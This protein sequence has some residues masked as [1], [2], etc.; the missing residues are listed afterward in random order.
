MA[1]GIARLNIF[2]SEFEWQIVNSFGF[3]LV[4]YRAQGITVSAVQIFRV[5]AF[6]S[7][8]YLPEFPPVLL[9]SL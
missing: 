6:R 3:H 4:A 8:A 7:K 5:C 9:A 2:L 1:L